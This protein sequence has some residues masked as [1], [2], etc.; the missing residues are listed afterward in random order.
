MLA[1]IGRFVVE[2][3]SALFLAPVRMGKVPCASAAIIEA[4]DNH[5]T[6]DQGRA[7]LG[8]EV[9]ALH[10]IEITISRLDAIFL[11]GI[12]AITEDEVCFRE[13]ECLLPWHL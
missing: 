12:H 13:R 1:G 6:V 7:L 11:K 5:T 2:K 8:S 4:M 3:P 9:I 10:S